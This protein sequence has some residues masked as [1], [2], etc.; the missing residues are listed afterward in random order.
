[1]TSPPGWV[2]IALIG[3]IDVAWLFVVEMIV[4]LEL[5]RTFIFDDSLLR[6]Y[7]TLLLLRACWAE[8]LPPSSCLAPVIRR[9]VLPELDLP[10]GSGAQNCSRKRRSLV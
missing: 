9:R 1:M 8:A 7:P 10:V 5:F 2:G 6:F 3:D 4:L